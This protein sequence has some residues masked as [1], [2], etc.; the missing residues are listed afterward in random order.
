MRQSKLMQ[1]LTDEMLKLKKKAKRDPK[2]WK[3]VSIRA[4]LDRIEKII[5]QRYGT[6]YHLAVT[7]VGHMI[8]DEDG[9]VYE[10]F[11]TN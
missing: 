8:V 2:N 7:N 4:R 6:T 1:N 9:V 5:I 3:E 10:P 11:K